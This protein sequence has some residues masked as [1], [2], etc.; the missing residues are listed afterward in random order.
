MIV[1]G[2]GCRRGCPA[3]AIV[4]LVHQAEARAACRVD[5]LAAP[6]FK[7]HEPGLH[8]AAAQLARPLLFVS[9]AALAQAQPRC[10]TRSEAARRHTGHDSIAEAAALA[11]TD[12]PLLLPRIATPQATCAVAG[13][14]APA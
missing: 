5:A 8:A 14:R 11:A 1:A 9:E 12:G 10:Q 4:A 13:S 7:R 2:I 3:E 6:D